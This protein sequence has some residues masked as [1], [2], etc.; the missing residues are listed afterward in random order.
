M[1]FWRYFNFIY[2]IVRLFQNIGQFANAVA[3][4]GVILDVFIAIIV[5][6]EGVNQRYELQKAIKVCYFTRT[7]VVYLCSFS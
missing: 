6:V 7:V 5:L 1:L 3:F 4:A 2:R